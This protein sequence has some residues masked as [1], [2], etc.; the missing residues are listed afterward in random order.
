MNNA[1]YTY[2]EIRIAATRTA[3]IHSITKR[4]PRYLWLPIGAGLSIRDERGKP[5]EF[6]I[7]NVIWDT[8][9]DRHI[10]IVKNDVAEYTYDELKDL[11]K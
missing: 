5:H 1:A 3:G 10:Y 8:F 6:E 2:C 7:A 4:M 11:F 9:D